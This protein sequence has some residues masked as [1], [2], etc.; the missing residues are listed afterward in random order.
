MEYWANALQIGFVMAEAQSVIAM[1]M[2]GMA[3]VWSVP[4][5]ENA[6]MLSEKVHAF[7]KGSTDAGLAAAS[8]KSPDAVTAAAIKPIRR[9]T[10]SN[11]RRLTKRG[12]KRA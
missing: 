3:G 1:R 10:R 12:P 6:R 8:G 9:A 2:M 11:H 7:I 5:T 4:K